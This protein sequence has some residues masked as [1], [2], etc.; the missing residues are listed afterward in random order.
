MPRILKNIDDENINAD[1]IRYFTNNDNEYLIYSLNEIDGSGYTKLYA[2]KII[3]RK[4]CIISDEDE[5]NLTREI[6]KDIVR[7]NRDGSSLNIIDLN[8]ESLNDI[9]LQSSRL[10]KLQ[11]NLVNLLSENKTINSKEFDMIKES[12][13]KQIAKFANEMIGIKDIDYVNR[14]GEEPCIYH[15]KNQAKTIANIIQTKCPTF[16]HIAIICKCNNEAKNMY[17]KLKPYLDCKIIREPEDYNNRILI[18][19]CAT[20]KGIEFDT[21]IIPNA[22]FDNYSNTIDKNILYVSSTR[23]L[24][25]LYFTTEDKPSIF[26]KNLQIIKD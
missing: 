18:T 12:D 20:A 24:H 2:S 26:I 11:G 25:K 8:E 14:N 9:L 23:A 16:E 7:S 10:F 22:S 15:S 6:I 21:V 3:G 1:I 19:T 17:E 5:W 4:A 13:T